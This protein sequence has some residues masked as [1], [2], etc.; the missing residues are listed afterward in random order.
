[1]LPRVSEDNQSG[2]SPT[3]DL[4]REHGVLIRILLIYNDVKEYLKV[5]NPYDQ[6][7][8]N[9]IIMETALIAEQF[10]ENYHQRLEEEYVFPEFLREQRLVN[11]VYTLLEQ[12]TAARELNRFIEIIYRAISPISAENGVSILIADGI[13]SVVSFGQGVTGRIPAYVLR[14]G[15]AFLAAEA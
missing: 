14:D 4:M 11:L 9:Y 13:L 6:S 12:H 5:E 1:L 10:I 7:F 2:I 8:I 15:Q 3:E